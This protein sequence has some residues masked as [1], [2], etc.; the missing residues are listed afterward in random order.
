MGRLLN[1]RRNARLQAQH[2]GYSG[3]AASRTLLVWALL[4][5]AVLMGL[6]SSRAD[7]AG[8]IYHT[9]SI[10]G[11]SLPEYIGPLEF[12][13]EHSGPEGTQSMSYSYRSMG[14]ALEV[15]VT[16][17]GEHGVADGA[18]APE[19]L[20]RYTEAKQDV[21]GATK[22]RRLKPEHE[23][24][25]TLGPKPDARLARE[26]FFYVKKRNGEGG[27]TW[28]IFTAAHGLVIDARFD[29]VQGLEE[30]GQLSHGEILEALGAAIPVSATKVAEARAQLLAEA[31]AATK[32][33]IVWDPATPE[34]ESR[35]WLGY[36]Y[37]RAAFAVSENR[38]VPVAGAH[39]A[40][41]EE[42]LRGRIIA[43]N[44][45]RELK[46]KG[47]M[48]ASGYFSDIDRVDAAGFLREYVWSYLKRDSWKT[49][50]PNLDMQGFNLWRAQNLGSDHVAVTHGTIAFKG[51]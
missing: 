11:L 28:L 48:L 51:S 23:K 9:T 22:L 29:A 36:L 8:E 43:V 49:A 3:A 15:S 35:I 4:L 10:G 7:A 32:V 47:A 39:D 21:I 14:L 38:G 41:F 1:K 20:Q 45:F 27:S 42:E 30:D 5:L 46:R 33:S 16:D 44:T 40:S 37:A 19:L 13:G 17:L 12:I 24:E 6:A 2:R 26:A 18:D 34:Q 50:P 31:E 25:V